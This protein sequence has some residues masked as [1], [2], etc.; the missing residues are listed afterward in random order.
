MFDFDYD[1]EVVLYIDVCGWS[2]EM[3]IF[4]LILCILCSGLQ[5]WVV[6]VMCGVLCDQNMQ[7][8]SVLFLYDLNCFFCYVGMVVFF[9]LKVKFE[10]LIVM[11]SGMIICCCD[12]GSFGY[13][14]DVCL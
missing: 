7:M 10:Y 11:F 8:V 3:W 9:N 5:W 4:L 1:W 6:V 14:D 13:V 12:C 2:V